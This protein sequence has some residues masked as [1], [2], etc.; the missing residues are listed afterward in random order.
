MDVGELFTIKIVDKRMQAIIDCTDEYTE[1]EGGI[2]EQQLKDYL[3]SNQVIYGISEE[4]MAKI[5][6]QK[7]AYDQFPLIIATGVEPVDGED[8]FVA[9]TFTENMDSSSS[10][11]TNFRDVMKIPSVKENDEI[12]QETL[13]TNGKPGKNISGIT[14]QPRPGKRKIVRAGKNVRYDEATLTYYATAEGQVSIRA[15][16]ID[17]HDLFTVPDTLSMETGNIDFVGSVEIHGDV[18]TGYT[19]KAGGDIRVHGLV[20]AAT[21]HAGGSVFISEG[22]AALQKGTIAAEGDI[23]VSYINQGDVWAGQSIYVENSIL[24]ST[25]KAEDSIICEHG[26]ITGGSIAAGY[27]IEAR[28]IG[29]RVQTKTTVMINEDEHVYEEEERLMEELKDVQTTI[30]QLKLIGEKLSKT[31]DIN[32]SNMRVTLLR[33]KSSLQKATME[34]QEIQQNIDRLRE[35]YF[36]DGEAKIIVKQEL[37]G[38]VAVTFGKYVQTTQRDYTSVQCSFQGNEISIVPL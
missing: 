2:T 11:K 14:I 38:N 16:R 32:D 12:A 13:P 15:H 24:H 5:I 29:N 28:D 35:N 31:A 25:C 37:F 33:Q 3:K 34:K 22:F 4:V 30:N 10:K 26:N 17:V 21:L 9:Y 18:P 8:G 27:L 19:I 6:D 20:E 1:F 23:H 7:V 36:H